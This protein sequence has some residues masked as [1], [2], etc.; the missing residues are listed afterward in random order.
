MSYVKI[1]LNSPEDVVLN[2]W[3]S[4]KYG[5]EKY[6]IQWVNHDNGLMGISKADKLNE[7]I[8]TNFDKLNFYK[9]AK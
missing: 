8:D 3:V 2:Y 4:W 7:I 6:I 9:K 5:V 1:D